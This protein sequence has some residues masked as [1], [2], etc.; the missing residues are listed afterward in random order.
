MSAAATIREAD[1]KVYA[2]FATASRLVA[3]LVSEGICLAY[4][5]PV[6]SAFGSC[7]SNLSSLAPFVGIALLLRNVPDNELLEPETLFSNV[8]LTVPLRSLPILHPNEA[9]LSA[10]GSHCFP[11]IELVDPWDM[12][13]PH[14]FTLHNSI[15]NGGQERRD[16]TVVGN[17]Q[18]Y[19]ALIHA[20]AD[21]SGAGADTFRI[22]HGLDAIQLWLT[23]ASRRDLKVPSRLVEEVRLELRSSID[24]QQYNY[25]H[26]K[27]LPT[28]QSSTVEWEQCN[29]EGHPTHPVCI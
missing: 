12:A 22:E 11:R 19:E 23:V 25:E 27:R 18:H 28:L 2:N 10:S 5:L 4:F 15:A 7:S 9:I 21:A 13:A 20:L 3:C 8:L 14:L 16:S 17:G 24:F 6:S 29:Y 26:P 1:A